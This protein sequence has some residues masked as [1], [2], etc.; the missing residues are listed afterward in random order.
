MDI[1]KLVC[2][3][4]MAPFQIDALICGQKVQEELAITWEDVFSVLDKESLVYSDFDHE[5]C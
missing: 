4:E 5:V 2:I 1:R 3:V